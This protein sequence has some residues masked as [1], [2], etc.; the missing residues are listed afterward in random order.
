MSYVQIMYTK[1]IKL[2]QT[3]ENVKK[4]I[5]SMLNWMTKNGIFFFGQHELVFFFK[6]PLTAFIYTYIFL[7]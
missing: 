1:D 3:T 2:I 7:N 4:N 6:M 5:F